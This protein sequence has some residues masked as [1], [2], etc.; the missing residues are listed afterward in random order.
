MKMKEEETSE[1]MDLG[2]IV[3]YILSF[4]FWIFFSGFIWMV[5]MK[6]KKMKKLRKILG[7]SGSQ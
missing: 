5:L 7:V 4:F 3:E 1:K 6:M 2:L